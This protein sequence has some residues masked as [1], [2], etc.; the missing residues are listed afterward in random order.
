MSD[1]SSLKEYYKTN[2]VD[3]SFLTHCSWR[4]F[5]FILPTG[6]FWKLPYQI[7][8]NK[9][10]NKWIQRRKPLDV[11]YSTSCW[12]SP[13]TV[14]AKGEILSENL[15]LFSDLA[16]DIDGKDYRIKSLEKARKETIT[17]LEFLKDHNIS[18]KYIAFSG[19]KGFHV[20]CKDP[21]NRSIED[22]LEREEKT[23]EMKK[24]IAQELLNQGIKIDSRVT[25]DSRRILRVPG[26][27]NSRSGYCCRILANGELQNYHAKEIVKKTNH[28]D[29]SAR[30]IPRG[31]DRKITFLRKILGLYR[32]RARSNPPL[33]YYA[34]FLSNKV[35][36][37]K[38]FIPIIELRKTNE[39]KILK[40]IYSIMETYKLSDAFLF[41]GDFYF[42]ILPF[43]LQKRRVEKILDASNS[44]NLSSFNKYYQTFT[45]I[46]AKV[47]MNFRSYID[48]P[49]FIRH[50]EI[51]LP[52]KPGSAPHLQFL[53][54]LGIEFR[55][56]SRKVGLDNY[57][58]RHTLIET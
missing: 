28:I 5:R 40:E 32:F 15:F 1:L 47:D 48:K 31:N 2:P 7:S 49:S 44:P 25:V 46:S 55:K 8:N 58:I 22:P 53:I 24:Q 35:T 18:V 27:I 26:T 37:T 6:R 54:N 38:L 23:K 42:A 39:F 36:G 57:I 9:S 21:F 4:Q 52:E 51:N 17:L 10:F 33:F 20:V 30:V 19:S 11:Y 14:G 13:T 43:A 41:K 56:F 16:F 45:R 3:L 34:S 50:I 29:L 12:L